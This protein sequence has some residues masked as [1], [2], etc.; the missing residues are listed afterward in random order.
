MMKLYALLGNFI[1]GFR[2]VVWLKW[3]LLWPDLL[4]R[5]AAGPRWFSDEYEIQYRGMMVVQIAWFALIGSVL[6]L[7]FVN[8]G[9]PS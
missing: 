1:T 7:L 6:L 2:P 3:L 5:R 8:A 4:F 9:G